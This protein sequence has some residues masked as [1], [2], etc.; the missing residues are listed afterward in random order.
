[1]DLFQSLKNSVL[2]TE[3][4]AKFFHH[5]GYVSTNMAVFILQFRRKGKPVKQVPDNGR[6]FERKSQI[7]SLSVFHNPKTVSK[8][9]K[10]N[11]GTIIYLQPVKVITGQFR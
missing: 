10:I 3:S 7:Q 8:G 5:R 6:D 4:P 9:D 1:M 2:V 11:W